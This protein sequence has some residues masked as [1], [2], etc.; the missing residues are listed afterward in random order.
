[1]TTVKASTRAFVTHHVPGSRSL[2]VAG[3][4]DIATVDQL[5]D[6]VTAFLRTGPGALV[7]DLT[8]LTFIDAAGLGRIVRI[9]NAQHASGQTMRVVGSS[10]KITWVF[11]LGGLGHLLGPPD[12]HVVV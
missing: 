11:T 6:A 12:L 10:P 3:E 5:S 8:G 1:M 4:L 9:N 2:S 7:L